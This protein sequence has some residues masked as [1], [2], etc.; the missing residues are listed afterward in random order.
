MAA[1]PAELLGVCSSYQAVMPHF[2]CVAE[3]FPPPARP[4]RAPRGKLRR[5]RQSRFKTQPV[6]FDEIQ[7][8]E[9]EGVSPMEEEKAK[10]S[11]LQ[12]LECLR[13]STQNLSL[14]R[15]RLGSCRLRNSLDSSDSDSAL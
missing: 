8:V 11:F 5:P 7:E 14:Q 10:K 6:T 1:K 13:R 12:S 2:V 4:A 15:D 9:E 3:E